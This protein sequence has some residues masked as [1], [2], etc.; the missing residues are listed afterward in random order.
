MRETLADRE[1]LQFAVNCELT[2]IIKPSYI[3]C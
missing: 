1:V 3:P 2:S